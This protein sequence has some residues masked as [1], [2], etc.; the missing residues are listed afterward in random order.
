MDWKRFFD[1]LGM[2]G[3]R[4]QWRII[5]WERQFQEWRDSARPARPVGARQFKFCD[6]CGAMLEKNDR[7]CPRCQARA[8]RWMA[9]KIKRT[10]GLVLP[11]WCPAATLILIANLANFAAVMALFGM[12]NLFHPTSEMLVRMGALVPPVALQGAWWQL[13]TYGYLHIGLMH[14]GFNMFAL[15]QVGPVL[16]EQVGGARFFVV[17]TLT[18]IGG[19]AADLVMRGQ[20]MIIVAGAS[21]ALFGLIGFGMSYAHFYGGRN[22]QF[23]R[24]FFLRWAIYG[25]IFGVLIGADNIAH[26]GGFIVGA[27]LGYVVE[28]ERLAR[29][30]WTGVWKMAAWAMALLTIAAFS[31]LIYHGITG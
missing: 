25:F 22:G 20:S 28:R 19:A 16:E 29:D 24:N 4:W 8:P 18:L 30:R 1:S 15:S 2:D 27:V 6:K 13:I 7:V 26:F 21:G 11:S 23:Q 12:S 5:R 14:I 3:T 9:W 31:A 17:Y 10:L